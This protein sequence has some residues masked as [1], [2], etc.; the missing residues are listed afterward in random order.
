MNVRGIGS[1]GGLPIPVTVI[2][3]TLFPRLFDPLLQHWLRLAAQCSLAARSSLKFGGSSLD[4][5]R[6]GSRRP[7]CAGRKMVQEISRRDRLRRRRT[8]QNI[9][10][11]RTSGD[12]R[13]IK[14]IVERSPRAGESGGGLQ[15]KRLNCPNSKA[16]LPPSRRDSTLGFAAKIGRGRNAGC[17]R[18]TSMSA[19][20][21]APPGW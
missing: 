20:T 8:H 14:L 15:G 10:G 1:P 17:W 5:W 16:T 19:T 2:P 7:R 21:T 3:L 4:S 12:G 18:W 9:F 6:I 11:A 13:G